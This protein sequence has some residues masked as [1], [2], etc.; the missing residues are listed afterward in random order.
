M[1]NAEL[2]P[3]P[4]T[5]ARVAAALRSAGHAYAPLMLE[6]AC[7]TSQEA[8]D[9]LRVQVAQIAKSVIFKRVSDEVAVL[10]VAAGDKRVDVAKVTAL[11]GEITRAD[12]NFVR[13]KTGFPIGGVSPVAHAN[14]HVT[15][16]DESLQ[17]FAI[18]WAAGGHPNSVFQLSPEDLAR[19]TSAQ[20]HDVAEVTASA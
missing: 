4:E 15:L 14:P 6:K 19:L 17:R 8:A 9:E 7:R 12:A 10:V 1:C 2:K 18:V 11:V 5:V 20:F 13:D 16:L 3:L